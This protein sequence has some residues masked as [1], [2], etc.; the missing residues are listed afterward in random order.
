MYLRPTNLVS[1]CQPCS[2]KQPK[3]PCGR[4][5]E[6]MITRRTS[7]HRLPTVVTI[8]L[9][10]VMAVHSSDFSMRAQSATIPPGT[11]TALVSE[12]PSGLTF[13][14]QPGEFWFV[15]REGGTFVSGYNVRPL[16]TGTYAI[17]GDNLEFSLPFGVS[18]CAG[19]NVF[20]WNLQGNK[21]SLTVPT[22]QTNKCELMPFMPLTYFRTDQMESLWKNIGPAGGSILSLLVYNGRIFAGTRDGGIFVSADNG[23]SWQ[24]KGTFRGNTIQ[25]LAAFNGRLYAGLSNNIIL[26]S[27]D[28]G[29]TWQFNQWDP[30]PPPSFTVKDFAV[31]N[32]RLYA[33]VTEQ[34]ILRLT[35]NPSLWEKS[36]TTGLSSLNVTSLAVIGANL[37]AGTD[38]GG[39]FIS[40]DG[41]NWSPVNNG[42]TFPRISTLAA[43]GTTLYAGTSTGSPTTTPNE[44]YVSQNNGQNWSPVG[45][46]LAASFP[47]GYFN[48]IYRL[49][50]NGGKLYAASD[51]GIILNEG[52]TWRLLYRGS[53]V[54]GYFSLTGIGS[55][56]FAGA[57]FDG[58]SRSLDGGTTWETINN[59]MNA[60]T[61]LAVIKDNG[62]LYAGVDDGALVSA[63][64]GQTWTRANLPGVTARNFLAFDG[65]V[66]AGT[67]FGVYVTTSP[68]QSWTRSSNGLAAGSVNRIVQ[69]GNALYAAVYNGGVF[70]STDSG[71]NWTAASTGLTSSKINDLVALGSNLFVSTDDK[72]VLRSSD[73]GQNWSAVTGAGLPGG[74]IFAMAV[75]GNTLLAAVWDQAIYRSAD[76]G[77]TW[78][79]SAGGFINPYVFTLCANGGVMYASG[80]KGIGVMRST[81]SGQSWSLF[82]AGFDSRHSY[83]FFVSG[84]TLYAATTN[85]LYASNA[86]VNQKTSVSAASYSLDAIVEK[87][88]VAAFG[89][90]LATGTEGASS[91]PLPTTLAGTTVKIRDS[92]GVERLAPLFYVSP[93]QVN[94]EIPAGIATGPATVTISNGN[95]FAA[96]EKTVIKATAPSIFTYD[97]SGSGAAAALDAFTFAPGPFNATQPNGQPNII[98]VFGT[99][100]GGD[101]T[102]GPG[103]VHSSV[104]TRING[105]IVNTQYAGTAPGYVGLNQYN[106]EL[107]VGITAGTYS[108]TVSRGGV[109]SNLV[110]ITIR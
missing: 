108:F 85:G 89:I 57:F 75:T 64:D 93:G 77:E 88:I 65:K 10:L 22:G 103:D 54:S 66:F 26:F 96:I 49:L 14:F 52:T 40:T 94:Y 87:S 61:I 105:A 68:G 3:C 72:G 100:L 70:R 50:P 102:E 30:A 91:Q 81:D 97:S 1:E 17:S 36:G 92:N 104:T 101:A 6:I 69:S 86:L 67:T 8:S 47:A 2:L 31:F 46:G 58:M 51:N 24:V 53:F 80:G 38:G 7:K 34:G 19:K 39:V 5:E 4:K 32:G 20:K 33:G 41:N 25:A 42:L 9:L 27:Q 18:D 23:Q 21:L 62:V 74:P 84:A 12:L 37:F 110:T 106:I 45:N 43:S 13:P 63:N 55:Q 56:L 107:P 99:G 71:Q 79:K 35:D 98:A 44:V 16:T 15:L 83:G 78:A 90:Q 95:G 48:R 82:N 76:N 11:Y 60:R 29:E 59:G 28:E 109:T 73:Q